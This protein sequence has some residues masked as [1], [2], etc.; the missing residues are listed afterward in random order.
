[1]LIIKY[2]AEVQMLATAYK[3]N[4]LELFKTQAAADEAAITAYDMEYAR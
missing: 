3:S 4:N 2:A 1:M